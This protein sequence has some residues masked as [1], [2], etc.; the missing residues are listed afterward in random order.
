[1]AFWKSKYYNGGF[2]NMTS[3][4]SL[5][6][7]MSDFICALCSESLTLVFSF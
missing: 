7:S 2:E 4:V 3:F 6:K 1:M 5:D